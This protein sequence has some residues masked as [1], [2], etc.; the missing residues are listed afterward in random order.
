M[1]ERMRL[2]ALRDGIDAHYLIFNSE[3][4]SEA[5]R[6]LPPICE[7]FIVL[8]ADYSGGFLT[9][10]L[11]EDGSLRT[12]PNTLVLTSARYDRKNLNEGGE[13]TQFG[14]LFLSALSSGSG[15]V[16]RRSWRALANEMIVSVDKVEQK[17]GVPQGERSRPFYFSN[18]GRESGPMASPAAEVATAE[19]TTEPVPAEKRSWASSAEP[20]APKAAAE[21]PVSRPA[22]ERKGTIEIEVAAPPTAS[23]KPVPAESAKIAPVEL[24]APQWLKGLTLPKPIVSESEEADGP[25]GAPKAVVSPRSPGAFGMGRSGF[26]R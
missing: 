11:G 26:G 19:S 10:A 16:E 12:V 17:S 7:K 5:L 23:R 2:E 22:T 24:K 4:L 25:S 14:G 15:P 1:N 8:N 13:M 6:S 9:T 21:P 3:F 20:P 18:I